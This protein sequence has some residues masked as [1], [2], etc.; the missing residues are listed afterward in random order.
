MNV[1]CLQYY[2][3][4]YD[5]I[6]VE[7]MQKNNKINVIALFSGGGGLDL[8]FAA[9]GFNICLSTDI[10]PFSCQTIR[11]NQEKKN[12]FSSHPVLS[13]DIKKLEGKNI[14][15]HAGKT[16]GDI[17]MI[18][19]GPPCQSFSVF[20]KRQ[21]L[22]DPR[23]GLIWHFSRI[24]KQIMPKVFVFENVYGLASILNG[25][26]LA[27]LKKRLSI[28]GQYEISTQHYEMA[29]HGVPQ[30]RKRIFIIGTLKPLMPP[31]MLPK[32]HDR[33]GRLKPF[34]TVQVVLK[35][36]PPPGLSLPNHR[37]R[38]HGEEIIR[39]YKAMRYGM[40][41][42]RTRI[43]K[44][45][46]DKPSF[47]IVV[48]SDQGGGKGHVHPF[49]PREV[50]PRESARLQSFPDWWEFKGNVRHMIRQVGNAVPP[51]FSAQIAAHIRKSLFEEAFFLD[52]DSL[53]KRIGLEFLQ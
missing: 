45:H 16:K 39:R 33:E 7:M 2:M 13:E 8:G 27:E 41:D 10:D 49:Q 50:T 51:L 40:R 52:T 32:T 23:G 1:V 17:D 35:D 6:K 4:Y 36:M 31:P 48:G 28:G 29:E 43:N 37:Q 34:C 3:L 22:D 44:L 18:I 30:W 14:L 19:G 25:K 46:P 9:A 15:A 47:T 26:V 38:D 53:I 21:G 11:H 5:T 24:I 12:F 42:T 20:G